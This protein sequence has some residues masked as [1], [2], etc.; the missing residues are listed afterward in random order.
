MDG[1]ND[2]AGAAAEMPSDDVEIRDEVRVAEEQSDDER[3]NET[4]DKVFE[5]F[6]EPHESDPIGNSE[7]D[8]ELRHGQ[9]RP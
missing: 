7:N 8:T 1:R 6:S 9:H 2:G 5:S 4:T 3:L